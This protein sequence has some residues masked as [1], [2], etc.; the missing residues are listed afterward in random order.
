[1][2]NV[3]EID[4][5]LVPMFVRNAEICLGAGDQTGCGPIVNDLI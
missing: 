2:E 3:G 4:D 1:M 5:R